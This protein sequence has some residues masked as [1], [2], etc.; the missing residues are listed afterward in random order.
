MLTVV[1]LTKE[2]LRKCIAARAAPVDRVTGTQPDDGGLGGDEDGEPE[3]R[4]RVHGRL[5]LEADSSVAL[6]C[7]GEGPWTIGRSP[8]SSQMIT[9][10]HLTPFSANLKYS[11]NHHQGP[12]GSKLEPGVTY[13]PKEPLNQG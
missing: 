10:S 3:L 13:R 7:E 4:V 12:T 8:N 2:E 9:F 6:V 11:L 1:K 5:L